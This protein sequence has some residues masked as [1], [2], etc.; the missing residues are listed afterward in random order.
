M[1]MQQI[2]ILALT[3]IL[4]GCTDATLSTPATKT[5][6]TG[7]AF[8]GVGL[9]SGGYTQSDSLETAP[10]SFTDGVNGTTCGAEDGRGGVG[11]GSGGR[12]GECTTAPQ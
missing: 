10:A 8:D 5:P 11:L 12:T 4:A 9:G 3:A 2:A 1:K 6:P 7:A